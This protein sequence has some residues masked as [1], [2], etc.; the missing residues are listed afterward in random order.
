M[1]VNR[2]GRTESSRRLNLDSP[3]SANR[4]N[5]YYTIQRSVIANRYLII[6]SRKKKKPQLSPFGRKLYFYTFQNYLQFI[7]FPDSLSRSKGTVPCLG[8]SAL[9]V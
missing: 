5:K 9:H 6:K 7:W 8:L 2:F 1:G 3:D 4:D